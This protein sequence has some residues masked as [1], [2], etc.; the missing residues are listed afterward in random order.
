MNGLVSVIVPCYNQGSFLAETLESVLKQ[1]Y[2]LWEC[3]IVNDGSTDD[4]EIVAHQFIERDTRF[5]YVI[6][7]NSGLSA[8]R[9]AGINNSS[10]EFILPLDSDDLI[11]EDYLEK[12]VPVLISQPDTKIVYCQAELFGE[13][14]GV[15]ELPEFDLKRFAYENQIFCT[16]LYRRSD[17]LKTEGYDPEMIYGWEDWSLWIG[18]L[19]DG[20][21]VYKIPETCFYYR[22]RSGSM[23]RQIDE[24]KQIYLRQ[25]IYRKHIKFYDQFFPDPL[26]LFKEKHLLEKKYKVLH[27]WKF[28]T[29]GKFIFRVLRKL[30]VFRY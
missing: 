14:S 3:V 8:A 6:Q 29:A 9:N 12:A 18:L 20:G 16:A 19:K 11:S 15:W 7:K 27:D 24:S 2:T 30:G 5:K 13:M 22:I 26:M 4:T 23:V 1:R 17:Y 10:G 21:N 25:L 28:E